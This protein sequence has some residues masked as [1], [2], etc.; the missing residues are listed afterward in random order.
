MN[1]YYFGSAL[2]TASLYM[3]AGCGAAISFKSGELN[4]GGEGQVYLGGFLMAVLLDK[5]AALPAILALPLALLASFTATGLLTLFSAFLK[6][7]RNAD[8]LFTSYITSSAIIPFIDSLIS[9]PFR[10]HSENLLATPF[11]AQN[12]RLPS[13]LKPSPLNAKIFLA[14]VLCFLFFMLIFRTAYGRKLC[15]YGTSKKFADFANY[16][17]Q[18]LAA[19]SAFISGGMHGLCGALAITGTYFTCHSGFY[20]GF[21]W[22]SF[23]AALLADSNPLLLAPASIFLGFVTTYSSKFALYHNYGFDMGSLIQ[24]A[25]MLAVSFTVIK[26]EDK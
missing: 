21:G 23:S 3:V 22:N 16:P 19:S 8:F 12:F 24:G 4:L 26:R 6:K 17:S 9:G 18:K 14:P 11:I 25:V 15:I 20:S 7:R 5:M 13:I 1:M 10:S 2:N